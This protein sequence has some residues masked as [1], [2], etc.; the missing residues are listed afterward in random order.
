M[1]KSIILFYKPTHTYGC[2]S[3]WYESSFTYQSITYMSSEQYMMHQK[4]LLFHD[5]EIA[6]K[7]REQV[8]KELNEHGINHVTIELENV[9]E[10]CHE[11]DC[12]IGVNHF[13]NYH[14]HH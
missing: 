14:H 1:T 12:S 9:D 4:A 8:K 7:I 11:E 3:N 2:F 13:T 10:K 5:Q 6:N